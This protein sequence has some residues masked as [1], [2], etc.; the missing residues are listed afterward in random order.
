[1]AP[2]T[3]CGVIAETLI[4]NPSL[5]AIVIS[6][7]GGRFGLVAR[8]RYLP[9]YLQSWNRDLFQRKPVAH[10]MEHDPLILPSDAL[11][12]QVALLVST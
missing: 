10:L 8:G 2:S 1:M 6:M 9:E 11:V 5:Q 4:S 7:G 12:D 3:T